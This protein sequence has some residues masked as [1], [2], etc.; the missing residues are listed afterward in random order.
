MYE[1]YHQPKPSPEEIEEMSRVMEGRRAAVLPPFY[2]EHDKDMVDYAYDVSLL[3]TKSMCIVYAKV[4]TFIYVT[5]SAIH[6]CAK[7]EFLRYVTEHPELTVEEASNNVI[8]TFRASLDTIKVLQ[9][10]SMRISR[11]TNWLEAQLDKEKAP[12]SQYD[13]NPREYVFECSLLCSLLFGDEHLS[14]DDTLQWKHSLEDLKDEMRKTKVKDRIMDEV[15]KA[16]THAKHK[17]LPFDELS[18]SEEDDFVSLAQRL[19]EAETMIDNNVLS[20]NL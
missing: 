16:V 17:Q 11:A 5:S 8:D 4:A 9:K 1:R 12:A 7:N 14:P 3:E 6:R 10:D 2:Q 20:W 15:I 19:Y 18:P 13:K